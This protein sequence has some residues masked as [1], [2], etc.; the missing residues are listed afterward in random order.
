[1]RRA[2][3]DADRTKDTAEATRLRGESG[4]YV[5]RPCRP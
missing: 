5:M 1:M 3:D 2:I 4:K